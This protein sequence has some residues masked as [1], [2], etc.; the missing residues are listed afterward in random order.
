MTDPSPQSKRFMFEQSFDLGAPKA[1]EEKPVITFGEEEMALAKEQSY[2]QGFVAGKE[3]ALREMQNKQN[4]VLGNIQ[5]LFERMA[6]EIWKSFAVRK[7]AASDIAIAI[8]RKIIPEFTRKNGVQE[9][10]AAIETTIVEMITEPRLV[11]RIGDAHFDRISS[12]VNGMAVRLGYSGK[13]IILADNT[14]SEH[15]C[16]LEWAD[17]GMERIVNLTWSDIERQLL[18]HQTSSRP[19]QSSETPVA[20]QGAST[21]NIAV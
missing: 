5:I 18:R 19:P 3:A 11:L 10:L 12:E 20:V 4:E 8:A 17:G 13:M 6:D 14:L 15:D 2:G 7:Q 21:T 1:V 9:I 16:R